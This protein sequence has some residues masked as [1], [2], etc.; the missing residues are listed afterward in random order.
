MK[1]WLIAIL[2]ILHGA[3]LAK[4][5]GTRIALT[6]E[7]AGA[8]LDPALMCLAI[9][10]DTRVSGWEGPLFSIGKRELGDTPS[11]LHAGLY[12]QRGEDGRTRS[13]LAFR[14]TELLSVRDWKTDL[15]QA[16]GEP[17]QQYLD[18]LT[19]T[20]DAMLATGLDGTLSLTGH[21]LGGG[22]AAFCALTKQLDAHCFAAAPLGS[23]SQRAIEKAHPGALAEAPHHVIH[24]FMAGDPIPA[25]AERIGE[26]FGA[27]VDPELEPPANLSGVISGKEKIALFLLAGLD[28]GKQVERAMKAREFLDKIARHS[29]A[30]YVGALVAQLGAKAGVLDLAGSWESQGSFFQVTGSTASFRLQQNHSL[31]LRNEFSVLNKSLGHEVSISDEGR[32]NF[33]GRFLHITFPSFATM[34]YELISSEPTRAVQWRRVEIRANE[35]AIRATFRARGDGNGDATLLALKGIFHLMKGK[36]VTWLRQ[37]AD[38]LTP[39]PEL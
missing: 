30:N 38:P 7:L 11:G 21:S 14:G 23:G 1:A 26:H 31:Q 28:L 8:V 25:S 34:K 10:T 13:I 39:I 36:V 9:Y 18:A 6:P 2:L 22:L 32:W 37:P 35:E 19:F 17:P 12:R 15:E 33:D 20:Q 5:A 4:E 24:L 16:L 27:I 29:M 3:A